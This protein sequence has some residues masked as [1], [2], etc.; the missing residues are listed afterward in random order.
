MPDEGGGHDED[1]TYSAAELLEQ[2]QVNAQALF[3]ATAEAL[4][5]DKGRLSQWREALAATFI[6]GWDAEQEWEPGDILFALV[7]NY[8]SYGA[9]VIDSDFESEQPF[10]TIANLP[11]TYLADV[12]G[13]PP[14]RLHH[15][16]RIGEDLAAR[17]GGSLAWSINEDGVARLAVTSR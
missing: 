15:L 2:A 6:R 12:L 10:A 14:D 5:D 17:L 13:V 4:S 9:E 8:Q 11:N 3:L 16:F 1:A 7:T